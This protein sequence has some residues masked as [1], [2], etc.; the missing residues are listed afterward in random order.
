[1]HGRKTRSFTE[2][3]AAHGATPR[4]VRWSWAAWSDR[5]DCLV[6][7]VWRDRWVAQEGVFALP[8]WHGTGSDERTRLLKR[9]AIGDQVRIILCEA[10]DERIEPRALKAQWA[11]D[12]VCY[13]ADKDDGGGF[14]VRPTMEVPKVKLAP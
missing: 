3:F 7:T 14:K 2:A 6:L 10:V 13:L 4:N 8:A 11:D 5:F 12:R 9:A 1:M